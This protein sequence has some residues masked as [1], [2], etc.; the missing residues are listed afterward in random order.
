MSPLA[1]KVLGGSHHPALAR[2][3]RG[4]LPPSVVLQLEDGSA[5]TAHLWLARRNSGE[6]F[7]IAELVGVR[8]QRALAADVARRHGLTPR[9]SQVLALLAS[10]L[11]NLEIARRL[12]V[13]AGTIRIELTGIFRKLGVAT[14]LQAALLVSG[15]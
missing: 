13:S 6:P 1:E 14:R 8:A 9:E 7:V 11:S 10:G 3:V 12:G 2:A 15:R 4:E 5:A